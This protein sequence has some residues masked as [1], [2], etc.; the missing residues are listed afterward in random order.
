[1]YTLLTVALIALESNFLSYI[2]NAGMK[3]YTAN[4]IENY[5]HI[6]YGSN[7]GDPANTDY[8]YVQGN[9]SCMCASHTYRNDIDAAKILLTSY[10][11]YIGRNNEPWIMDPIHFSCTLSDF[12]LQT[13]WLVGDNIGS[14]PLF[15]SIYTKD[16]TFIVTSDL[17][18]AQRLGY[19]KALTALGP[20]QMISFDTSSYEVTKIFHTESKQDSSSFRSKISYKS[21]ELYTDGLLTSAKEVLQSSLTT[22]NCATYSKLELDLSLHHEHS[23]GVVNGN[24]HINFSF[25]NLNTVVFSE[26]DSTDSSS[27]L[28]KCVAATINISNIFKTS[29]P[30]VADISLLSP[31]VFHAFMK[32]SVDPRFLKTTVWAP[33]FERIAAEKWSVCEAASSLSNKESN[34]RHTLIASNTGLDLKPIETYLLNMFCGILN[35]TVLYPFNDQNFQTILWNA[36]YPKSY[37]YQAVNLLESNGICENTEDSVDVKEY[38]WPGTTSN[39]LSQKFLNASYVD[40]C[41]NDRESSEDDDS[42]E[43]T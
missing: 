29:R 34:K 32:D 27:R 41:E 21:I 40:S 7:T 25:N 20:G 23:S 16:K 37:L 28:L 35:V 2:E 12:G 36:P 33:K 6:T 10:Q 18:G 17:I 38:I 11:D 9:I 39:F 8:I 5:S 13:I 15:Y 19:H 31:E 42:I 22:N 4:L 26:F 14:I 1:M 43:R 24:N 3:I 30:L